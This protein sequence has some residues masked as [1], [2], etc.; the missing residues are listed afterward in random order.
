MRWN[1]KNI[2]YSHK[3]TSLSII[4]PKINQFPSYESE[5]NICGTFRTLIIPQIKLFYEN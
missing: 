5:I 1:M 3:Y 2:T 4:E